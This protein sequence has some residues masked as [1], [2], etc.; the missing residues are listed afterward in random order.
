MAP[1][2]FAAPQARQGAATEDVPCNVIVKYQ[3]AEVTGNLVLGR[4]WRIYPDEVM[5]QK[6][7]ELYGPDNIV[8]N[9]S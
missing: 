4:D 2:R 5:L 7:G 8:L 9:Y 1:G 6:L 3:C